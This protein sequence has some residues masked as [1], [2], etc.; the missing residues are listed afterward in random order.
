ME[1]LKLTSI[2]TFVNNASALFKTLKP[3]DSLNNSMLDDFRQDLTSFHAFANLSIAMKEVY[4]ILQGIQLENL[5]IGLR[6]D[7]IDNDDEDTRVE[8]IRKANLSRPVSSL[9]VI[10]ALI[11]ISV[12][13]LLI[14]WIWSIK[15]KGRGKI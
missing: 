14:L 1:N 10:F 7:V 12:M 5:V 15:A 8:L 4:E 3:I 11:V 6:N 13:V 2:S 9:M